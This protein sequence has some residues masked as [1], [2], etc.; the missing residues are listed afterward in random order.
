ML[1]VLRKATGKEKK[2]YYIGLIDMVL[3][4]AA[5]RTLD[6]GKTKIDL[7]T[8]QEVAEQCS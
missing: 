2:G 1:K 4:E 6:E 5:I 8:L 7:A 3:R